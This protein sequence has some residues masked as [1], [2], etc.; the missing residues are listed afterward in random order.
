MALSKIQSES[1]NLADDFAGMH[2]GGTGS[3][4]QLDDYEE[5]TWTPVL[6]SATTTTYTSQVGTY[7]KIGQ[8]VFVY[9]DINI[10]SV[11]DGSTNTVGGFPFTPINNDALAVSY[12]LSLAASP[13]SLQFQ[14]GVSG[15]LAVGVTT[16]GATI[17]NGMTI[18][19]NSARVIASGCYRTAA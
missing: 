18:F 16:A 14:M 6:A 13:Y 2:F 11:G 17:V 8:L 10:N 15:A 3:A 7:C 4:N 9:F 1:I 19:G 12:F 5:G